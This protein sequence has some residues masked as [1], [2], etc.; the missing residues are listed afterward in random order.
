MEEERQ[1]LAQEQQAQRAEAERQRQL[2]QKQKQEK[3]QQEEEEEQAQREAQRQLA[4]QKAAAAEERQRQLAAEDEARRQRAI[5][6]ERQRQERAA[7]LEA[8]RREE[9]A[10]AA[11]AKQALIDAEA[12]ELAAIDAEAR[13]QAEAERERVKA[14]NRAEAERLKAEEDAEIA[15]ALR[16]A[17]EQRRKR[18]SFLSDMDSFSTQFVSQTQE[19]ESALQDAQRQKD[20]LKANIATMP[21]APVDQPRVRN[22]RPVA[23][24]DDDLRPLTVVEEPLPPS[25]TPAHAEPAKVTRT[26]V[27]DQAALQSRQQDFQQVTSALFAESAAD[28]ASSAAP[29]PVAAAPAASVVEG[30]EL[31]MPTRIGSD[32]AGGKAKAAA[33]SAAPPARPPSGLPAASPAASSSAT[34]SGVRFGGAT[35]PV[36]TPAAATTASVPADAEDEEEEGTAQ[37]DSISNI[38]TREERRT[39]TREEKASWRAKQVDLNTRRKDFHGAVTFM[40]DGIFSW[41]MYG[42]AEALDEFG[43]TYTEYLMRCQWGTSFENLQPWIVAHRYREFDKLDLDL[44]KRFPALEVTMPKL[45]KKEFLWSMETQVVTKRRQALEEYMVKLVQSFPTLLRS[46]LMDVFL[47]ITERIQSIKN[48]LKVAP[49]LSMR[50]SA[51]PSGATTSAAST[52]SAAVY[53]AAEESSSVMSAPPPSHT[54]SAMAGGDPLGVSRGGVQPAARR[55]SARGGGGPVVV[56]DEEEHDAHDRNNCK[57]LVSA[58]LLPRCC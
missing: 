27:V 53:E 12:A 19:K 10:A 56:V 55:G 4:Q 20:A 46:D 5:D 31:R 48:L 54:S 29:E 38:L 22:H 35:S 26:I 7:A 9:A 13:R 18:A 34:H 3:Q 43:N 39:M 52:S 40:F 47:H 32:K 36:N 41:Q 16:R 17:E 51:N 49:S 33:A 21:A 1:R 6:E 23:D 28:A 25:P 14:A 37:L 44:K 30:E 11:A 15:E 45:P 2:L 50:T 42:S 24:D 8:R 58:P 57:I